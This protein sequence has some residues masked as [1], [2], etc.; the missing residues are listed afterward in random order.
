MQ[1]SFPGDINMQQSFSTALL[2]GMK[3]FIVAVKPVPPNFCHIYLFG[4]LLGW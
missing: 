4:F 3:I 1:Q 2:F